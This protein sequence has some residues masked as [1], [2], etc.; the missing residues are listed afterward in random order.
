MTLGILKVARVIQTLY[1]VDNLDLSGI[2]DFVQAVRDYVATHET[3]VYCITATTPQLPPV[4]QIISAIRELAP[5]ARIILGGPHVTLSHAAQLGEQ[6]RGVVSRAHVALDEL[7]K[8][9]DVLVAGDGEKTIKLALQESP[10]RLINGD[11]PKT[12]LFLTEEELKNDVWPLRELLDA[13]SYRYFVDGL[14]ALSIV[15]QLGCPFGCGF[16]GGRRSPSLRRKRSRGAANVV[17]E[18]E[19]MYRTYGNRG[20]MFYDD[21]L[22]VDKQ[23]IGELMRAI[24]DLQKRL[25]VQFRLRGFVKS[26]LFTDEQ[27]ALMY[28]AG[29]RIVLIGFES[30]S[31]LMLKLM[32]KQATRADNTRCMEIAARHGLK[33]KALMSLGHP[34]ESKDTAMETRDWL[35]QV[36]PND[37]DITVITVYPGTPYHDDSVPHPTL[38]NIWVYETK[39]YKL[40]SKGLNFQETANFY[41]GHPGEYSA[42]VFTDFLQPKDIVQ[43]RDSIEAEVRDKLGILYPTS[44]AALRYEHSM[45]QGRL[46][47]HIL[48]SADKVQPL[49]LPISRLSLPVLSGT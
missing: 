2:V 11:D 45:G 49:P 47:P 39:G 34:G 25:G 20:F 6:K 30:G 42:Y 46:P 24:I 5:N 9:A 26:Q 4:V 43:L 35:L 3:E 17:L 15:S 44:A 14:P 29:F 37:F 16:C 38:E 40:Y 10:D 19:H 27:A 7:Q 31:D 18:M 22:N 32:N 8:L 41:K 13:K 23:Q 1:P 48:Q 36:K 21:E 28:E 12:D 33:V